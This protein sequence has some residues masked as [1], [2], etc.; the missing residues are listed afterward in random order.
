METKTSKLYLSEEL[1]RLT[2]ENERLKERDT[3]RKVERYADG[4]DEEGNEVYDMAVCP[5]CHREFEV[6]YDEHAAYCPTCGQ[7]LDWS[8]VEREETNKNEF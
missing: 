2:E 4:Y 3:P 7:K 6:D 1:K 5:N 8:E